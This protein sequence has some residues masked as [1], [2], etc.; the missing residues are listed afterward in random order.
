M[1]RHTLFPAQPTCNDADMRG[2]LTVGEIARLL[3]VDR[4]V[5]LGWMSQGEL[6]GHTVG[7]RGQDLAAK[8]SDLVRFLGEVPAP[9]GPELTRALAHS[10]G[11]ELLALRERFAEAFVHV[12]KVGT[13]CVPATQSTALRELANV[14]AELA[15][16]LEEQALS[17]P[18]QPPGV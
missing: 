1:P 13:D 10:E 9:A 4:K 16:T 14:A 7:T 2:Y 11:T 15:G 8:R 18:T 6:Q 3:N 5:V 17:D 12:S